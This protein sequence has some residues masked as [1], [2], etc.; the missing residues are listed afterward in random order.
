MRVEERKVIHPK[1]KVDSL[2]WFHHRNPDEA[3]LSNVI[4]RG[5]IQ[6]LII[7]RYGVTYYINGIS[8]GIQEQFVFK[9]LKDA[10]GNLGSSDKYDLFREY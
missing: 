9:N 3:T 6:H 1:F 10:Y 8:Q 2:V 4:H 5:K 7:D